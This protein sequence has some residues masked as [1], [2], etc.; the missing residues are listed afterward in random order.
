MNVIK[1][2]K[3]EYHFLSNFATC[4]ITYEGIDYP[5]TEHAYQAAKSLDEN[6]RLKMSKLKTVGLSKREGQRIRIRKDWNQVKN[7]IM[8][9]VCKLKFNIPYF[10]LQLLSTG[11]AFLEEGNTWHDNYWGVCY[12][13]NCPMHKRQPKENQNHLGKILMKIRDELS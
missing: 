13:G 7:Q 2:F 6:V 1:N 11:G 12:C 4:P 8:Y 3:D 10:K 5:S 9:D